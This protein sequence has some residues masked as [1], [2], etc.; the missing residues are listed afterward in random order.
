MRRVSARNG[1]VGVTNLD[2]VQIAAAGLRSV[3]A[4]RLS[5]KQLR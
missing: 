3:G 2:R 5:G 1:V 4:S